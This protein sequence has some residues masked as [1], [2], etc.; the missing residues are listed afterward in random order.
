MEGT[1][2]FAGATEPAN[3]S[4]PTFAYGHTGGACSIIGGYVYRGTEIP[5]LAGT[6]VY[7]DRCTGTIGGIVVGG[8]REAT[9]ETTS[10]PDLGISVPG[11]QLQSF[12]QGPDG[13]LYVL[14]SGGQVA[15]I[16]PAP[17]P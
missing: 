8:P 12:G 5:A 11:G 9:A 4:R 10:V 3:H 13:A 14:S 16:D 15:R 7:G 2:P 6:Y 17:A 1:L